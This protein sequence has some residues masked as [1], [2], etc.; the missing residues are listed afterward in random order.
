MEQYNVIENL[1]KLPPLFQFIIILVS[2]VAPPVIV[3]WFSNRKIAVQAE[4]NSR[5]IETEAKA[6]AEVEKANME[7]QI[8]LEAVENTQ[9]KAQSDAD[10]AKA[11]SENTTRIIEGWHK[12][13]ERWQRN[14]DINSERQREIHRLY[15]DSIERQ[16]A[17]MLGVKDVID[18]YS[19]THYQLSQTVEQ[20]GRSVQAVTDEMRK[21]NEQ[22]NKYLRRM[23]ATTN[24]NVDETLDTTVA[25]RDRI[26]PFIDKVEQK[27]DNLTVLNCE[28]IKQEFQIMKLE[29]KTM[30]TPIPAIIIPSPEPPTPDTP[31]PRST[32]VEALLDSTP[33]V[34]SEATPQTETT[35]NQP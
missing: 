21:D 22:T 31:A 19:G 3:Q 5:Q 17:I 1:D 9:I 16:S 7:L 4:A 24:R 26:L 35:N 18:T 27:L 33:I 15:I 14:F 12:S 8:R 32:S 10:T 6:R 13:E 29:I 34:P 2:L 30:L 25:I 28:E 20:T 23:F 11:A